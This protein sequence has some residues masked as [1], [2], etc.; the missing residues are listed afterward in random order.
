VAFTIPAA[1]PMNQDAIRVGSIDRRERQQFLPRRGRLGGRDA[2]LPTRRDRREEAAEVRC[3]IALAHES[4]ACVPTR[5]PPHRHQPREPFGG[6][7]AAEVDLDVARAAG[8]ELQLCRLEESRRHPETE[9]PLDRV[10]RPACEDAQPGLHRAPLLEA[11]RGGPALD[12]HVL[13]AA[14]ERDHG[15][16]RP[17]PAEQGIVERESIDRDGLDRAWRE[18]D[19]LAG[20]RMEVCGVQLVQDR[21]ARQLQLVEGARREHARAVHR[22]PGRGVLLEH[23]HVVSRAREQARGVE[24]SRAAA[25]NRYV[26]HVRS[27]R[28]S[29]ARARAAACVAYRRL[30][31]V[32]CL[33]RR[34][35]PRPR[36]RERSRALDARELRM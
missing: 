8:G 36:P 35:R 1:S 11:Q 27:S 22:C 4:D 7:L 33:D 28:R 13:D 19:R 3:G 25:D 2:D 23:D 6:D 18:R 21:A 17:R 16:G 29:R 34:R 9:T 5:R 10:V 31:C 20:R 15:T 12:D 32:E 30:S 26:S 24:P 14:S